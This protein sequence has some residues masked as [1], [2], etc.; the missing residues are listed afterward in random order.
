M[1][2][3]F[4]WLLRGMRPGGR[5]ANVLALRFHC[6]AERETHFERAWRKPYEFHSPP[7][8]PR[9]IT[10]NFV[11]VATLPKGTACS[12]SSC[13][14]AFSPPQT[15]RFAGFVRGPLIF[16]SGAFLIMSVL[17]ILKLAR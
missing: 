4:L 1:A 2:G 12:G 3:L 10:F 6:L 5:K 16:K 14:M 8:P 7:A 11:P 9:Q 17:E 15:I 13:F